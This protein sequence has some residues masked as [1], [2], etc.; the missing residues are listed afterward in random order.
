MARAKRLNAEKVTISI[1]SNILL[2]AK[3]KAL[4]ERL[5]LSDYIQE[6]VRNDLDK[7]PVLKEEK[8][9]IITASKK[10]LKKVIKPT[11]PSK[12]VV[13]K[14]PSTVFIKIDADEVIKLYKSGLTYNQVATELNNRGLKSA[15]GREWTGK[16]VEHQVSK[17]K[18]S[19]I[20][21]EEKEVVGES[22]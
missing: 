16:M 9:V 3:H 7:R 19:L 13:E 11:I 12:P 1:D 14:K 6:L 22:D 5:T 2:D 18:K 15:T 21:P 10:S 20:V 4:D 8:P 17:Y